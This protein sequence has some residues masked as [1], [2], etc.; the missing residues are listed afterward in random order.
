MEDDWL[1][2]L[3]NSGAQP[4]PAKPAPAQVVGAVPTVNGKRSKYITPPMVRKNDARPATPT[5]SSR[6]V[7]AMP[8]RVATATATPALVDHDGHIDHVKP[9]VVPAAATRVASRPEKRAR[10]VVPERPYVVQSAPPP[11]PVELEEEPKVLV[12]ASRSTSA[13]SDATS[14]PNPFRLQRIGSGASAA[15]D[16]QALF[17]PEKFAEMSIEAA[18][19]SSA[20]SVVTAPNEEAVAGD[21]ESGEGGGCDASRR[22]VR[23]NLTER[24][25][26]DR[27]NQLFNKLYLVLEDTAPGQTGADGTT[28]LGVLGADCKP[29][30]PQR[31]SKADVLEGALNIITDLRRQLAEERLSRSLGVEASEVE[32]TDALTHEVRVS[33][34]GGNDAERNENPFGDLADASGFNAYG[35]L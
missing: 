25:R 13:S 4:F 29:I 31:W 12:P 1:T 27:M 5:M 18:V 34:F 6:V 20:S 30:N 2:A 33:S 28:A 16:V 21:D 17:A 24:R 11:A 19:G 26:V 9:D 22:K 7:V 35:M 23:H 32:A 15:S 14:A 8:V 3:L 10:K